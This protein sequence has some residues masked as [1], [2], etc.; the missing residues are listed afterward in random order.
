MLIRSWFHVD[1]SVGDMPSRVQTAEVMPSAASSEK[2][3]GILIHPCSRKCSTS[4]SVRGELGLV[5]MVVN[6]DER[7]SD[8][9]VTEDL[10][11]GGRHETI[12][13]YYDGTVILFSRCRVVVC[14]VA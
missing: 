9:L 13:T 14:C 5:A 11:I 4:A 8:E 12:Y 1:L 2:Q 7:R 6:M 10:L 3:A